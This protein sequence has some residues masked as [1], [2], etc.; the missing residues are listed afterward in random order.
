MNQTAWAY[1]KKYILT[2]NSHGKNELLQAMVDIEIAHHT[3]PE[4]IRVP[5]GIWCDE[6]PVT[7]EQVM[8]VNARR[9]ETNQ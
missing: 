1:L 9:E 4:P 3:V 6:K 5:K 7:H 2:K 8:L